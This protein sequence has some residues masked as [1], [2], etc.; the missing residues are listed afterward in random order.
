MPLPAN[1]RLGWKGLSEKNHSSLLLK[2]VSYGRKKVYSTGPGGLRGTER[3]NKLRIK[4]Y[5]GFVPQPGKQL[6]LP[7]SDGYGLMLVLCQFAIHNC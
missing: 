7:I 1:I 3:E 5:S 4:K 6:I 2:S